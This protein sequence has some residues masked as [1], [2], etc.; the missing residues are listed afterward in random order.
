MAARGGHD[1]YDSRM[2]PEGQ[3][4]EF[5]PSWW[6]SWGKQ[7][8]MIGLVILAVAVIAFVALILAGVILD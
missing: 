4:P 3:G 8:A 2:S 6:D 7:A 5:N 1:P